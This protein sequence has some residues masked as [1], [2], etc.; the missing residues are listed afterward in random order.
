MPAAWSAVLP[1]AAASGGDPWRAFADPLLQGLVADALAA[2]TD[3]LGAQAQLRRARAARDAAAAALQPV[4]NASAS[5]GRSRTPPLATQNSVRAGF[6][7][8]WEPDLFGANGHASAAATADAE[9]SAASLAATRLAVAGEVALGYLQLR[10]TQARLVLAQAN[11]AAQ[12]ETLQIARWRSQAGL[13][14]ALDV[15]QAQSAVEQTRAQVPTLQASA[16]Q[17][18]HALAVLTG[19]PPAALESQ[20]TSAVSLPEPPTGLGLDLPASTLR[21]RPDVMASERQLQ[22]AAE[23]VAQKQ[24]EKRPQLSLQGSLAWSALSLGSLGSSAAAASLRA[25]LSQPLFDGGARDAALRQQEATFDAARASYAASVLAALQDVEDSVAAL[26]A[27]RQRLEALRTAEQAARDAAL[28]AT[29]RYASGIV[30]F[31]VVLDTQRTLL[32]VQDSAA[33]AQTDWV[34]GHVRVLKALG[35]APAEEKKS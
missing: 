15:A 18:R 32:S 34:S 25:G 33:S 23:R 21:R 22:A 4:L 1:A 3:V 27:A 19:R 29:Q 7:A 8:S 28:L 35:I 6:D 20:L 30:D 17:S 9:A 2:N 14:T 11:L 5:A 24:A 26:N 12:E 31:Q 13:A 16:A 10:G